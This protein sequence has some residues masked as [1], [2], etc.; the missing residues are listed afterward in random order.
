LGHIDVGRNYSTPIP[1]LDQGEV[2]V[3]KRNNR[4]APPAALASGS[5]EAWKPPAPVRN[6]AQA[7]RLVKKDVKRAQGILADV[8]QGKPVIANLVAWARRIL[9]ENP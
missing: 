6:D 7:K 1:G 4:S 2:I 5:Q 9:Q 8:E 3:V